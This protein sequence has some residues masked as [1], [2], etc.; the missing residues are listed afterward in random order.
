M[1]RKQAEEELLT[2]TILEMNGC[3]TEDINT[4]QAFPGK[5]QKIREL[6]EE[7]GDGNQELN[8]RRG[9]FDLILSRKQKL[10]FYLIEREDHTMGLPAGC[11]LNRPETFETLMLFDELAGVLEEIASQA[12]Q[13]NSSMELDADLMKILGLLNDAPYERLDKLLDSLLILTEKQ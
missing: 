7:C 13:Q 8:R 10:Q 6:L 3:K 2:Q 1:G 4:F 11:D 5:K 9:L 12:L